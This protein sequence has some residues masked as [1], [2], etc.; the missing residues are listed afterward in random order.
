M[1]KLNVAYNPQVQ[2]A[3]GLFPHE[4]QKHICNPPG[5]HKNWGLAGLT[6]V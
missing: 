6:N 5:L 3:R 4:S 1:S 2:E